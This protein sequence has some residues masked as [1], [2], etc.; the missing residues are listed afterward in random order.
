MIRSTADDDAEFHDD[1]D[2][3]EHTDEGGGGGVG[4]R[5]IEDLITWKSFEMGSSE[6]Q[7]WAKSL[8]INKGLGHYKLKSEDC[9]GVTI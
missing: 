1:E 9:V 2:S 8:D 5:L 6:S 7:V 3:A 4:P